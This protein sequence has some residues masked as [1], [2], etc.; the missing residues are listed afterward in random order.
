MPPHKKRKFDLFGVGRRRRR[1]RVERHFHYYF[2]VCPISLTHA[3][4]RLCIYIYSGSISFQKKYYDSAKKQVFPFLT[5]VIDVKDGVV[6]GV[7]WDDA[8]IFCGLTKVD[9]NTLDFEGQTGDEKKFEQVVE[10][11][12]FTAE[13]CTTKSEGCDLLLH[14]VWTGTDAKGRS[15]LSSS[16]RYSAFP[17]QEWGDRLV[18]ILPDVKG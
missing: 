16:Y 2:K 3:P 14:V 7:A 17:P 12:Y 11:C 5:A 13:E 18:G 9:R 10:G 1:R 6:M 15:F 4:C 8:S